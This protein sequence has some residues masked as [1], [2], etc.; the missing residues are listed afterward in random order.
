VLFPLWSL[1][2]SLLISSNVNKA[3]K[4]YIP[5]PDESSEARERLY[6]VMITEISRGVKR[7]YFKPVTYEAPYSV[8]IPKSLYV[9]TVSS[10]ICF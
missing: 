8:I 3:L 1:I 2:P 6:V 9:Q 4:V 7:A 10:E 5:S